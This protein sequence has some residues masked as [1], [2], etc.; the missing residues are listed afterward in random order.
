M[1]RDSER[2]A[3][4][5]CHT[6]KLGHPYKTFFW[7]NMKSL[8]QDPQDQG[9]DV[10]TELLAYYRHVSLPVSH[11]CVLSPGPKFISSLP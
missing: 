7:G 6:S 11:L 2:L 8:W 1:Q 3:Q 4:L 9:I 10:R 5:R